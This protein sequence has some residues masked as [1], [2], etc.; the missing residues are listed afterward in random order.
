MKCGLYSKLG[1]L[2]PKMGFGKRG[3]KGGEARAKRD[4]KFFVAI[5]PISCF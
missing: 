3:E 4:I 2:N 1:E 5:F